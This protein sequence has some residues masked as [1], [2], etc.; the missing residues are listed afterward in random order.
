ML[1]LHPHLTPGLEPPGGPALPVG[2]AEPR[3]LCGPLEH[4]AF[5]HF[6]SV[7][8]PAIWKLGEVPR[9]IPGSRM[10]QVPIRCTLDLLHI[11]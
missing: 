4:L 2:T 10:T 8:E 11:P 1:P 9:E 7:T 5:L 3:W 6:I